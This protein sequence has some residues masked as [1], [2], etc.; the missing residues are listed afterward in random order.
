MATVA[1]SQ[2][3]VALS[4]ANWPIGF[5]VADL[6]ARLGDIPA[7]RILLKPAPGTATEKDLV[8]LD[9][10]NLFCEL[11]D[12]VLVRKPSVGLYESPVAMLVG[13]VLLEFVKK[14]NLGVVTGGDGP[15]RLLPANVRYP[16]AAFAGWNTIGGDRLPKVAIGPF[17]PD[18][19]VEVLSPSNT[20]REMDQKLRDYF[21]AGVK[22]VWYIDP[23]EKTARCFSGVDRYTS[24]DE[25]GELIGDPVLPGFRVRLGDIFEDA[26]RNITPPEKT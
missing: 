16:D 2:S 12:G 17:A 1:D 9:D 23:D 18:L 6:R 13:F 5:T 10:Q 4:P 22:I 24:I 21:T 8:K 11:I 3:T 7:E 25:N 14:H 15:Y 19:A 26:M 20:K